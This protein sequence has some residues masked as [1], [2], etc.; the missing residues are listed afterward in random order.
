MIINLS[1]CAIEG[2]EFSIGIYVTNWIDNPL[3]SI[4]YLT[5]SGSGPAQHFWLYGSRVALFTA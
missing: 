2:M 1:A 4:T 3:Q 5:D